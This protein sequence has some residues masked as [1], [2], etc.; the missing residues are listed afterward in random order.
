MLSLNK[1]ESIIK[2]A[3]MHKYTNLQYEIIA[4]IK[5]RKKIKYD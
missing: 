1:A 5:K 4:N 3:R 2:P